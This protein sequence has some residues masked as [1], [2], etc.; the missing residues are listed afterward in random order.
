MLIVCASASQPEEPIWLDGY[1]E[2]GGERERARESESERESERASERARGGR[3]SRQATT[4]PAL[5]SGLRVPGSVLSV[6]GSR[7]VTGF[8][9]RVQAR[10]SKGSCSGV[11]FEHK[12]SRGQG[13]VKAV[14][15]SIWGFAFCV[16]GSAQVCLG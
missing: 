10:G 15:F 6:Q 3:S 2:S 14:S 9:F 16:L 7:W 4:G 8:E 12:G 11:R 13:W 5:D 1:R